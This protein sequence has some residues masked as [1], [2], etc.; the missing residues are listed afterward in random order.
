MDETKLEQPDSQD[1][2]ENWITNLEIGI[3]SDEQLENLEL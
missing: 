3:L 2:K 1:S